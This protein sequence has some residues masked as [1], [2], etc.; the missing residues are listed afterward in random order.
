MQ[1]ETTWAKRNEL[2]GR[3]TGEIAKLGDLVERGQR[4]LGT[5]D[6]REMLQVAGNL[7]AQ[8]RMP[9]VEALGRFDAREAGVMRHR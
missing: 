8:S 3:E 5:K 2:R 6:R 7:R 1:R 4:V 9:R